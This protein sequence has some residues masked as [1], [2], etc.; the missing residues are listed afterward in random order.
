MLNV[1]VF[2]FGQWVL[3]SNLPFL[4]VSCFK[5]ET[6]LEYAAYLIPELQLQDPAGKY[7]TLYSVG[8]IH[9]MYNPQRVSCFKLKTLQ[10]YVAYQ[11]PN[12]SNSV[13][14]TLYSVGCM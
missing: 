14:Q 6:L 9:Y 3:D 1:I 11:Y 4:A 10:E 2:A 13:L 5:H 7:L 12:C 8:C